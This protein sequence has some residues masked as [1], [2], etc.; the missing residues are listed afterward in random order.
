MKPR[1]IGSSLVVAL[2]I[3]VTGTRGTADITLLPAYTVIDLG[4]LGGDTGEAFAV[5]DN[6]IVVGTS[7]LASGFG[8]GFRY[9]GTGP[10]QDLGKLVGEA[11]SANDVNAAGVIVGTGSPGLG[12]RLVIWNGGPAT[13]PAPFA[14]INSFGWAIND[15]N[16]VAGNISL[17]PLFRPQAII[18]TL[19][20]PSFTNIGALLAP[21][22]VTRSVANDLNESNVAV[23][24]VILQDFSI[25]ARGFRFVPPDQVELL[26]TFGIYDDT[27][28]AINE[29]GQI[30]GE[31]GVAPGLQH[32]CVWSGGTITDI[33][34]FAAEHSG[35]N[36]INDK[37]EI[38]GSFLPTL[39]SSNVFAFLRTG[40]QTIDLNTLIAPGS[41]WHL[42]IAYGINE[43][44][45]IVGRGLHN[46]LSRA[47]LLTPT[48][49]PGADV[50]ATPVDTTAGGTP[51]QLTFEQVTQGGV[52][53]VSSSSS[54]P[55]PPDGFA[56]GTPAIYYDISTTV[57]FTGA[58][59]VCLDVT[60]VDFGAEPPSLHHYESGSWVMVPSSFD[61]ATN[62]ICG[63]VTSLSPF[64]VFRQQTVAGYQVRTLYDT[65]RAARRGSTLPI[66]L[67]VRDVLG[68][69]V[70]APDLVVTVIRIEQVSTQ[71]PGE[72]ADSGNSN[73]DGT[74]RYDASLGAG[75]G[76]ILNLS[77]SEL[78]SGTH[79]LVFFIGG[80]PVEYSARFQVK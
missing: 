4:T 3:V 16:T 50:V 78:D 47:F 57:E 44:S 63:S 27:P 21:L 73:P 40:G 41:G 74:F 46:G 8:H 58:V 22:G 10:I 6:G 30:V 66:K 72:V 33:N 43:H 2:F 56:V 35:A 60:G 9:D 77:T 54:G 17:P 53:T 5:N 25:P 32:A 52:S 19:G 12:N 13:V 45:Q 71:A 79:A 29:S 28:R 62:T 1:F 75:G 23:G 61:P 59:Q 11:S 38:V 24:W 70:S 26:P 69:N 55:P 31:C 76:Y 20:S 68:N 80:S 64:A 65:T 18:H 15:G 7:D 34:P 36:D 14:T 49:M 39:G 37:G 48:T 42:E 51:V 67:E